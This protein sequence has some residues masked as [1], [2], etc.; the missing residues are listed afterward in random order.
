MPEE[1]LSSGKLAEKVGLSP[2][3]L[4]KL[5]AELEIQPAQMKGICAMYDAAA[6]KKVQSSLKK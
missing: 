6:L 3:K 2:A 1:L 5:L 4:K